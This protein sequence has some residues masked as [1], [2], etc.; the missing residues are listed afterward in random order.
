M[1]QPSVAEK[2]NILPYFV[3]GKQFHDEV[4][5]PDHLKR[6][7]RYNETKDLMDLYPSAPGSEK[8]LKSN[9]GD[10][11]HSGQHNSPSFFLVQ[12][13]SP[14]VDAGAVIGRVWGDLPARLAALKISNREARLAT[15]PEVSDWFSQGE[16]RKKEAADAAKRKQDEKAGRLAELESLREKAA[17]LEKIAALETT[18][19]KK[20]AKG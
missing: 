13:D 16:R 12:I 15:A 6:V 8:K 5:L 4:L 2:L 1:S 14:A 10:L 7:A 18:I 19:E 3:K 11:S 20:A 9:F 17:L